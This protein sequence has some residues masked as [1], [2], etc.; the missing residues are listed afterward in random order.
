MV[1]DGVVK[2]VGRMSVDIIKSG[3][4]K[5]SAL[6]IERHLLEHSDIKDIAV[7]GNDSEES[8]ITKSALQ[9]K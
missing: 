8:V 6:D 7:I 1:T 4:Y 2:I 5:I 9:M 3:G